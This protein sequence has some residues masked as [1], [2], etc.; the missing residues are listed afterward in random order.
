MI[1][2]YPLSP[3]PLGAGAASQDRRKTGAQEPD[4]LQTFIDARYKD[5]RPMTDEE[6][7]GMLIAVLFAGQHT[8]SIT[9][10]WTGLYMI[11]NAENGLKPALAEQ[12]AILKDYGNELEMDVL[13]KMDV[14]HRN[15]TE[16]LRLQPPLVMLLRK[17]HKTFS[18]TTSDG[19]DITIPKGHV[20]ATSPAF[21]HTLDTCFTVSPPL[22]HVGMYDYAMHAGRGRP[23]M[24]N[25]KGFAH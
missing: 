2:A 19:K 21:Q 3:C 24:G 13:N 18:V 5:G 25:T 10:T 7:T 22:F 14:L 15:M 17:S 11:A 12:Q 23:P 8:S 1:A 9:S 20:L 16:A 6:I 4:V